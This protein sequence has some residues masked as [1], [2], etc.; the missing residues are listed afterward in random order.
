VCLKN[1]TTEV[2][3]SIICIIMDDG[4]FQRDDFSVSRDD[5]SVSR[6]DFSV[7]HQT[8]WLPCGAPKGVFTSR[9]E[10]DDDLSVTILACR[11]K[12]IHCPCGAP[13]E[14]FTARFEPEDDLSVTILACRERF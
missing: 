14:V 7:S 2:K 10:L 13:K 12:L 3:T 11:M 1:R 6:D 4:R 9:S 8:N 5:S